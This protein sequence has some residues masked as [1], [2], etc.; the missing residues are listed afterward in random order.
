MADTLVFQIP[1]KQSPGFA[2][3]Q[4]RLIEMAKYKALISKLQT[5]ASPEAME[6]TAKMWKDIVEF[7]ADFVKAD[8][9]QEQLR[10]MWNASEE[11]FNSMFDALGGASVIPP[12][13]DAPSATG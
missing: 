12:V 8:T 4:A 3:R 10:L 13:K 2:L 9:R 7:L 11:Q 5:D 6:Q 1:T